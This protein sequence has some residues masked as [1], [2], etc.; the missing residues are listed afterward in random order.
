MRIF[1]GSEVTLTD[2]TVKLVNGAK[3]GAAI[4][5]SAIVIRAVTATKENIPRGNKIRR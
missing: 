3:K 4:R 1:I 5:A 2:P